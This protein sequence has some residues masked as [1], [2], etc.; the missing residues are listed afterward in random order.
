LQKIKLFTS[1]IPKNSFIPNSK[2]RTFIQRDDFYIKKL[3]K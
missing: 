3:R 1:F 2:R